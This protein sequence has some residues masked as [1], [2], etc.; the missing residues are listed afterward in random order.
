M[1][2]EAEK[3]I[4][5]GQFIFDQRITR[6]EQTAVAPFW[7]GMISGTATPSSSSTAAMCRRR[8]LGAA[9]RRGQHS[10]A[11][12][13]W[14]VI[15]AGLIDVHTFNSLSRSLAEDQRPMGQKAMLE[16]KTGIANLDVSKAGSGHS[17]ASHRERPPA[18]TPVVSHNLVR[19]S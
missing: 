18:G 14:R 13:W 19:A 6:C 12:S 4:L 10:E 9:G 11:R 2:L 15:L 1:G 7:R 17:R 5:R 3:I 8:K 16:Y